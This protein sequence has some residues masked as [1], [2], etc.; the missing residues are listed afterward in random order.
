[1]GW[2][3]R[4]VLSVCIACAGCA[5][6]GV[7][8]PG[9]E[10]NYGC[11]EPPPDTF[12]SAGVD[13]RFAES[14]FAKVV[15]GSVDFK[16]HPS[17]VTLASQAVR[18]ARISNYLQCLALKRDGFT[19]AQVIYQQKTTAFLST[20]PTAEEFMKWQQQEPFP[21]GSDEQVKVLEREVDKLRERATKSDE[22]LRTVQERIKDR[23]LTV[24]QLA[25]MAATLSKGEQGEIEI[26]FLLG[27][28]ES[29]HFAKD[30]GV[31][32]RI[33]GWAVTGMHPYMF[34]DGT[35]V[36]L[37]IRT[38]DPHMPSIQTLHSALLELD[39]KTQVKT[40]PNV[41]RWMQLDVGSKP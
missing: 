41:G 39:S 8:H 15:T 10:D 19:P 1:M 17:V 9:G 7:V 31:A 23:R 20:N 26:N 30:I 40:N 33:G 22:E 27:N 24:S 11:K 12:T 37:R 25:R 36:G 4:I 14:M 13:A 29:E 18:D 3:I 28:S 35:P 2:R 5:P 34:L 21:V 38:K 32:L 6:K 16:T